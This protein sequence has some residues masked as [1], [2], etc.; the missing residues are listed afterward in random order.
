MWVLES[1]I[2]QTG[3]L[4]ISV[5]YIFVDKHWHTITICML[6]ASLV[7]QWTG[8]GRDSTNICSVVLYHN[9]RNLH[10]LDLPS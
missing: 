1:S 8:S 5:P 4:N 7:V 9:T 2:S 6:S 10:V 3:V